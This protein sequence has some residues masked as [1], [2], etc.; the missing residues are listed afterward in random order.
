MNQT[1]VDHETYEWEGSYAY[2]IKLSI[3][4]RWPRDH[5]HGKF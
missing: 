2:C 1:Y 5:A 4:Y 3:A